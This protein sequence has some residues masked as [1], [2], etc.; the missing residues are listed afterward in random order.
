MSN[1]IKIYQWLKELIETKPYLQGIEIYESEIHIHPEMDLPAI[2]IQRLTARN[3]EKCQDTITNQTDIIITL[4]IPPQNKKEV[5]TIL[6]DFE[7][8]I[9]KTIETEYDKGNAPYP[10]TQLTFKN[11]EITSYYKRIDDT[12][13]A[14]TT[15]ITFQIEYEI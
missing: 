11:S 9:R 2:T 5:N 14:H 3:G 4:W 8:D 10:I 7:E 1:Y 12:L 6:Y 13:I 15:K